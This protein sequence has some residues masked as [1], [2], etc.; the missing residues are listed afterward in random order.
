MKLTPLTQKQQVKNFAFSQEKPFSVAY[1]VKET[2]LN[3]KTV[4]KYIRR[5]EDDGF[6]RRVNG[7]AV[8]YYILN[9]DKRNKAGPVYLPEHITMLMGILK[10]N[11]CESLRDIAGLTGYSRQ[12][13]CRYMQGMASV[14]VIGY[15][16]VYFIQ[17]TTRISEVGNHMEKHILSRLKSEVPALG[18][19]RKG[20]LKVLR[21]IRKIKYHEQFENASI[22]C[23]RV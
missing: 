13:V 17:D 9:R 15:N 1:C 11:R 10:E 18:R 8:N 14:G 16:G 21:K 22:Y 2:G 3:E 23:R 12:F 19:I 7:R 5:L 6:V 4:R 20:L